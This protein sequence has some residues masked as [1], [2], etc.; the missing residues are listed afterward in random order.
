[1]TQMTPLSRP[2]SSSVSD[3]EWRFATLAH[4]AIAVASLTAAVQLASR[5]TL[6]DLLTA[7]TVCFA[8]ALPTSIGV[9]ALARFAQI[10]SRSTSS[11]VT[12]SSRSWPG[13]FYL[14]GV[15]DQIACFSGILLLFWSFHWI[16]GVALLSAALIAY[17]TALLMA[18]R[19]VTEGA[20][21]SHDA[22]QR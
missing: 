12:L 3:D 20:N 18:R 10:E 9:V 7:A 15:I 13:L 8:V 1:M 21:G 11:S 5:E 6:P 14:I 22:T 19:R 17:L 2:Q 4:S 16:A